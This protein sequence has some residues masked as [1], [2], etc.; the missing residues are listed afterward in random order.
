MTRIP[1][2]CFRF[3]STMCS[4]QVSLYCDTQLRGFSKDLLREILVDRGYDIAINK[5]QLA[6]VLE[7]AFP[8]T[9]GHEDSV[10]KLLEAAVHHSASHHHHLHSHCER[11]GH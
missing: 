8:Y 6:A 11:M 2:A 4:A 1:K 9:A 3:D 7:N 10:D 5:L